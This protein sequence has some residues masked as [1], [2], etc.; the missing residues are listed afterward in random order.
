[1]LSHHNTPMGWKSIEKEAIRRRQ[2]R[3]GIKSEQDDSFMVRFESAA[4]FDCGSF[5][6]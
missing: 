5:V 1:M 2:S 3:Q 6:H 4:S